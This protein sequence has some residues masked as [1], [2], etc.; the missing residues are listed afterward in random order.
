MGSFRPWIDTAQNLIRQSRESEQP[1]WLD[2]AVKD[3][4][5]EHPECGLSE[6]QLAD[7]VRGLVVEQ[8]WAIA[9]G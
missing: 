9:E 2:V 3:I 8:R 5:R 1:V 4:L 6:A 7:I